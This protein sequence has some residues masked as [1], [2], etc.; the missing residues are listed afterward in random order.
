MTVGLAVGIGLVSF[1]AGDHLEPG[2]VL[3]I[4]SVPLVVLALSTLNGPLEARTARAAA[5]V[6]SA[7]LL[8]AAW[9]LY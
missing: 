2:F 6:P 9:W 4:L 7:G 1:V 3:G 5:V 8:G